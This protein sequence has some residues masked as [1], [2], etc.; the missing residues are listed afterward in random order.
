MENPCNKTNRGISIAEKC[1]FL[2]HYLINLFIN[3]PKQCQFCIKDI[4]Y[5]YPNVI[6]IHAREKYI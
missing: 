3:P 6:I 5:I 4:I 2:D 1:H